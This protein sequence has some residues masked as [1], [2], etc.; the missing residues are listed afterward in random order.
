MKRSTISK[1]SIRRSF[2]RSSSTYDRFS[3]IQD[4]V[5]QLLLDRIPDQVFESALEI[6]CGTGGFSRKLLKKRDIRRLFLIDIS[7]T[8]LLRAKNQLLP[9]HQGVAEFLCCD[10]ENLAINRGVKFDLIAS[11]SCIHW[12]QAPARSLSQIVQTRLMDG[13][14]LACAIFGKN[15]LWEL[16]T[17]I[18]E[19]MGQE[20]TFPTKGFPCKEDL[21]AALKGR[22][23]E[24]DV[25]THVIKREYD[26]LFDLLLALK[27]TGT[28]PVTGAKPIFKTRNQIL[29]AQERYQ[30]RF[31][32][33]TA[34]YEIFFVTG[35]A[36][37]RGR[38]L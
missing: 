17:V 8:M 38:L 4:R 19:A 5:N 13:G 2:S 1:D 16:E 28:A 9:A 22:L 36:P 7:A 35:R 23:R 33:V 30:G 6:G 12:F 18:Q 32:S 27:R 21:V 3:F 24:L 10:G 11:A 14:L 20:I 37:G 15:T 29:A 25:E 31:G 26:S 34:S